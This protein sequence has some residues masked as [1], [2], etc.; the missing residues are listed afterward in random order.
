MTGRIVKGIGG[1][2]SV[3]TEGGRVCE[4]SA[5]GLF[6]LQKISP[7]VGDEV[8]IDAE[9]KVIT[10][11][12]PRANEMVRPRVSNVS[13]CVA[14]VAARQPEPDLE[15]LDILLINAR[16][17]G[18]APVICVTKADLAETGFIEGARKAYR[19]FPFAAVSAKSGAGLAEIRAL[20]EGKTS[21]F[22]GM[23]GAGKSSLLNALA[24]NAVMETGGLSAKTGRG[25]HTTRHAEMISL[26]GGAFVIDTPGFSNIALAGAEK[27][28][29]QF[30]Y[31]EFAPFLGICYY[32]DCNHL[33]EHDCAVKSAVGKEID[34]GRY[35]RY[36]SICA[37]LP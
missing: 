31:P 26:G 30:A 21:V 35:R 37:K 34:A 27:S 4:C 18:L 16:L 7:L 14:V 36:A 20:L 19:A 23:S 11:I 22:A 28:A 10:E 9:A 33:S 5:R 32:G 12:T 1:I 13:V 24:E 17:G 29:L 6:R 3:L 2:Y 8:E 15:Y 25:K